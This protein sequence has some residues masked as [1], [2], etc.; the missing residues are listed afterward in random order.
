M[1]DNY[2]GWSI[3]ACLESGVVKSG[4]VLEFGA[5]V[6][7]G[8]PGIRLGLVAGPT[9]ASLVLVFT[10]ALLLGSTV[11]LGAHFTLLPPWGGCLSIMGC[12]GFRDGVT[13][14]I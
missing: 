4:L 10:G 5:W 12:L 13:Q 14:V 8:W 7:E 1:L 11:K 6:H 3:V 9:G 2:G